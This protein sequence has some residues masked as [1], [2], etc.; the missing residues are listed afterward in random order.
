M[1]KEQEEQEK[2]EKLHKILDLVIDINGLEPRTAAQN[3]PTAFLEFSGHVALLQVRV[4]EKGWERNN[5]NLSME[6]KIY[7][8]SASCKNYDDIIRKLERTKV[9]VKYGD[10]PHIKCDICGKK[11]YKETV[12]SEQDDCYEVDG[13]SICGDCLPKYMKKNYWKELKECL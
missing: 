2:R 9:K 1:V 3:K 4:Y 5:G 11:I 12:T 6:K 7:T 10:D 13:Y 8:D